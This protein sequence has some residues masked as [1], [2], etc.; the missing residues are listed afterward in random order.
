MRRGLRVW[1]VAATA[2]AIALEPPAAQ[3]P[4]PLD[5]FYRASAPDDRQARAAMEELARQW[6]DAY[7]PM[8]VD[9]ARLLRPAA[10]RTPDQGS[11]L[12][13]FPFDDVDADAGGSRAA[14]LGTGADLDA[15]APPRLTQESRIRSRLVSF[16]ERQT[17]KRFDVSLAG[18]RQWMWSLPYDP[19]PDYAEFK[20][21]VYSRIDPRMKR[22][23]PPRV[24]A[25]IRLDEIDWGGVTVNGIPPLYYPRVLAASDAR[26]LRDNHI[27]FGVVV[28]GEAR[29][30]PKRILAWHELAVDRIGGVEM[31]VVYC[32][33][34]GTVI[35]YES[36]VGGRRRRFGTSGLLYRSNKLMFDE[37]TA[38]LWS[39]LEGKPVVG[40][41]VDSGLSLTSHASVTT[42]WGEWRAA[43]PKT[44][45]LSLDTGHKRD[46]SEGA[47]YRDYFSHDR[48]YFQVPA[49]DARLKNKTEVLVLQVAP[50]AG[51]AAQPVAIVASFLK[52][53]PAFAFQTGDRRLVVLTTREGANRVYDL[54]EHDLVFR[55]S[56]PGTLVDGTGREWTETEDAL[57]LKG[58][59]VAL[60]RHAAHRA[61]WFGWFAQYP[62]TLLLGA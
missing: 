60:P 48:L 47:A 16:L 29:A 61:F 1:L 41:L 3:T 54:G 31:T 56:G 30:Y 55:R 51:G 24:P 18:W 39:T 9:L 22:F 58:G 17:K 40:P 52:K 50:R 32:T 28:N 49:P 35:P 34:C 43:H 46:Y 42:T 6:R 26:Y 23:F 33:L 19:H 36:E 20:G 37:E 13:G 27:V 14:A 4:P 12:S 45:V 10:P 59:G 57:T 44:T 53:S 62:T 38:S 7:T 21:T 2:S 11:D 15:Q 5:L 8:I 25:S